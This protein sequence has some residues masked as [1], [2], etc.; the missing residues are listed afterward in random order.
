MRDTITFLDTVQ[1]ILNSQYLTFG[2]VKLQGRDN[3]LNHEDI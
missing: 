2:T 1:T 3:A